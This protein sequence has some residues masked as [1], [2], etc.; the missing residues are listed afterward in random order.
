M[1]ERWAT[2]LTAMSVN[3]TLELTVGGMP[4]DS[5]DPMLEAIGAVLRK[6]QIDQDV[7][8]S[9]VAGEVRGVTPYPM[10]ISRSYEW[11]PEVEADITAAVAE[12]APGVTPVITWGSPD[13]P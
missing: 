6:R 7:V 1:G 10:I 13:E 2:T 9:T 3:L 4:A 12:V 8:L 5:I 11:C